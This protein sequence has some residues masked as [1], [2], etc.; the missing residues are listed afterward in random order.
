MSELPN[1]VLVHGAWAN[2]SSWSAVIEHLQADGY[3]VAAP[4][5]PMT[6]LADD[7]GLGASRHRP[8]GLRLASGG[9]LRQ[10]LRRRC[11][12]GHGQGHVRGPAAVAL[13]LT[14]GGHGRPRLEVGA[15]AVPGRRRRLG[16]PAGWRTAVD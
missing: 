10:P 16:D 3:S 13:E 2:G 8:A 7:V 15:I 4:G 9:R 11:R 12:P 5:F 14:W 6:R 1:I